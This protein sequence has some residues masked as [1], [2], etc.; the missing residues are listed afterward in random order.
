ME[1]LDGTELT[2]RV[3][4]QPP[5]SEPAKIGGRARRTRTGELRVAC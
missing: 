1:S 4:L 3:Q 2:V 5:A